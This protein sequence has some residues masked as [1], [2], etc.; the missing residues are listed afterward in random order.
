MNNFTMTERNTVLASLQNLSD[1][2]FFQ[3]GFYNKLAKQYARGKK[4][5]SQIHNNIEKRLTKPI[6]YKPSQTKLNNSER[7]IN[8]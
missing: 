6:Y 5:L 2:S 4:N 8:I 1:H 3:K 7:T